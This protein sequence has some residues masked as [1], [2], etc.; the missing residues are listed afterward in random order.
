[1]YWFVVFSYVWTSKISS[2]QNLSGWEERILICRFLGRC[3]L[4]IVRFFDIVKSVPWQ[5]GIWLPSSYF[6]S[7][8][9]LMSVKSMT[10]SKLY[11]IFIFLVLEGVCLRVCGGVWQLILQGHASN[12]LDWV[13]SLCGRHAPCLFSFFFWEMVRS[14]FVI[15][16]WYT[17]SVSP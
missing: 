10:N 5:A 17:V 3:T 11:F 9:Y 15:L 12:A 8:W 13:H 4:S 16:T 2:T 14:S 6:F 1:M 7:I